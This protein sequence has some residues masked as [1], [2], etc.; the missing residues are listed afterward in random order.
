M[1]RPRRV[2]GYA[3]VSSEAQAAGT[4]LSDQQA[5]IEANA[6]SRG[7]KVARFFVEAES[8]I[9]EKIE[10]R[11]QIRSLMR[12][13]RDG[14]LVL[15]D[16]LDRWSRDPEFT[17][18]SV[19]ELGERGVS[20]YAV[21]EAL[22]PSTSE[23]DTALGFRVLFAREEHKRIR[24]RMVGTRNLLRDKG[25]YAE[26]L[27][28]LG[29]R[30]APGKGIEKLVL[31][32]V[33]EEAELVQRIFRRY[34]AGRAM[35]PLANELGLKLDRVKD[36]LHRRFYT[37]EMRNSKGEW[38]KGK[39]PAIIDHALFARAQEVCLER[40]L[41]GARPRG[42]E[43][44]RG[45]ETDTWILRDVATCA[46]CGARMG[47]SYAG[48][49][50][51][52]RYYYR[53]TRQCRAKGP[54]A[55]TGSYV[56]VREV[57]EQVPSMLYSRLAEFR[58]EL[59][60]PPPTHSTP[61]TAARRAKLARKRERFLEAFADE[62]MT[63]D[64]LRAAMARL[65]T[66]VMRLDEEDARGRPSRLADATLRKRVLR[67]L[68]SL[69]RAVRAAHEPALRQIVNRL[70]IAFRLAPGESPAPTWRPLE[71]LVQD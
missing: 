70:A 8:A 7:L 20:F 19:R 69:E 21:S 35:V 53:C 41:G 56:P 2:L 16:K 59:L 15:V 14:D 39:H 28:P 24:E 46:L 34:V 18:K 6:R 22:D 25:Y 71:E 37:G 52:R 45:F 33:P 17:Y 38:I 58:S 1:P 44:E 65:D 62:S 10:R 23:G 49:R 55:R 29:Y 13:A 60:K 54:R 3:R 5:S 63:R 12:E 61:D 9:H 42:G 11:E 68:Q 27:P 31:E 4:S 32:I 43:H 26:G 30:R 57:E 48:P 47:A 51:A 64:E 36:A 40:T 67:D 50:T 66:E